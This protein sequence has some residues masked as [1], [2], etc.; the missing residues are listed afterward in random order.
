MQLPRYEAL[1]ISVGNPVYDVLTKK[2][3]FDFANPAASHAAIAFVYIYVMWF[4]LTWGWYV[5]LIFLILVF[6]ASL[7]GLAILCWLYSLIILVWPGSTQLRF[8]Q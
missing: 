8:F 7:L 4:S 5:L 1:L 2:T 3:N 6:P